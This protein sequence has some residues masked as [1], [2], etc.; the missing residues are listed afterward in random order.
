[1]LRG[2]APSEDPAQNNVDEGAHCDDD[3]C[4]LKNGGSVALFRHSGQSGGATFQVRR[5]GG[6][7]FALER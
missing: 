1:M 4:D 2:F 3:T 5:E 6:K 7:G